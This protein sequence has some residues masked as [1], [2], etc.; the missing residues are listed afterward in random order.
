MDIGRRLDCMIICCTRKY[1]EIINKELQEEKKYLIE[2]PPRSYM[3]MSQ[4][5]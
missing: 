4:D 1:N 2:L 5:R 3:I